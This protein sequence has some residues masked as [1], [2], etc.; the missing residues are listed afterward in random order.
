MATALLAEHG[1]SLRGLDGIAFGAGPGSF[2]G[3]RIACGVS[4]GLAFGADL[5]VTG[6]STLAALAEAA[7]AERVVCCLDAR[8]GQ[9]YHA[10]YEKGRT[11]WL[12]VHEPSLTAPAEAPL[13]PGAALWTGAGAG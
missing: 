11:D 2:T 3:L 13:P 8:M 4:Q 5:P 10:A 6:V 7:G 1:L 12:V 9:V